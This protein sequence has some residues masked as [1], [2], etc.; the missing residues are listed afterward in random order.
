MSRRSLESWELNSVSGKAHA[1]VYGSS[2]SGGYFTV[3]ILRPIQ[4][5]AR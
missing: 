5:R 2:E 4:I 1:L 3:R